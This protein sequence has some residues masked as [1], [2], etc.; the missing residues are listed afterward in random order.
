MAKKHPVNVEIKTTADARGAKRTEDAIEDVQDAAKKL[1]DELDKIKGL[2]PAVRT[3]IEGVATSMERASGSAQKLSKGQDKAAKSQR[4]SGLAALEFSRA[5]EDAQ[6]GVRGVLNNIPQLIQFM[7]GG[8][9]LA[10]V[11]SLAAVALTQ[12]VERIA[13][14]DEESTKLMET[15]EVATQQVDEFYKAAAED[16]TAAMRAH[17]LAVVEALEMQNQA[18][19]DNLNLTR[20]KRDADLRV[21]AAGADLELATI[22]GREASGELTGEQARAARAELEL[23][24]MR[25]EVDEKILRA[26]EEL[27]LAQ[28]KRALNARQQLE[29]DA[30]LAIEKEKAAALLEE[31]NALQARQEIADRLREKGQKKIDDSGMFSPTKQEEGFGLIDKAMATFPESDRMRLKQ[32]EDILLPERQAMAETLESTLAALQKE[33]GQLSRAQGAAFNTLAITEET[34]TTILEMREAIVETE[35]RAE[36]VKNSGEKLKAGL[37]GLKASAGELEELNAF[38]QASLQEGLTSIQKIASDGVVTS[39]QFGRAS[40]DLQRFQM[41][42]G[43]SNREFAEAV[44]LM[45]A[46]M[47]RQQREIRALKE[48]ARRIS[49]NSGG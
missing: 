14:T 23:S 21:A 24:R 42:F 2:D 16:G 27:A 17:L 37:D 30:R 19:Q 39:E 26:E 49:N 4:N 43:T 7:G 8:A 12:L 15:L 5:V 31:Q 48:N 6:Y 11:V 40:A 29:I 3:Q 41:Q 1:R 36:V 47:A 45:Q 20:Q 22:A 33:Q 34:E 13:K 28:E 9:G 10:G 18:L 38:Q 32:L 46:E 35:G 25:R 44:Q